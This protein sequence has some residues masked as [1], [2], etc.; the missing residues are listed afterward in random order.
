METDTKN[1]DISKKIKINFIPIMFIVAIISRMFAVSHVWYAFLLG[2]LSYFLISNQ[3][4]FASILYRTR[5]LIV[6]FAI[7]AVNTFGTHL[8]SG[9]SVHYT[10]VLISFLLTILLGACSYLSYGPKHLKRGLLTTNKI[11]FVS[12]IFGW[13]ESIIQNNPLKPYMPVFFHANTV[14]TELYRPSSFFTHAIPFS[15]ILLIGI[16]INNTLVKNN[17]KRFISNILYVVVLFMTGTRSAWLIL[18][19]LIVVGATRP[20]VNN[21]SFTRNQLIVFLTGVA[22]GVMA[23]FYT[24]FGQNVILTITERFGR[25]TGDDHGAVSLDQRTGAIDF[26]LESFFG[27]FSI[28]HWLFGYGHRATRILMGQV[29]IVLENFVTTDNQWIAMLYNYGLVA[30]I[31]LIVFFVKKTRRYLLTED[32]LYTCC[33]LIFLMCLAAMFFYELFNWETVNVFMM[34]MIGVFIAITY[35]DKLDKKYLKGFNHDQK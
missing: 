12:A 2:C 17:I 25:L 29:V 6:L 24:T 27:T 9:N 33:F 34:M 4:M 11:I 14:G 35:K 10:L 16:I 5:Y 22:V 31:M 3:K 13:Y 30:T 18:V 28:I 32:S 7:I 19:L 15:N 20:I 21:I 8:D 26:V 23:L 1:R